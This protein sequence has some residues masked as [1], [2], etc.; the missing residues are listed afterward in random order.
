M[1]RP[2]AVVNKLELSKP[3][4]RQ[5][6]VQKRRPA[7]QKLFAKKGTTNLM[8]LFRVVFRVGRVE[9]TRPFGCLMAPPAV[10]RG[11]STRGVFELH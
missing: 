4:D 1:Q 2:S 11:W 8:V 5:A 6:E 9:M 3:S 7:A 10:P